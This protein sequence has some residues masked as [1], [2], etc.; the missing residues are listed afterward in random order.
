MS[1]VLCWV[2]CARPA[3]SARSNVHSACNVQYTLVRVRPAGRTQKSQHRT[4]LSTGSP[5][6]TYCAGAR[7]TTGNPSKKDTNVILFDYLVASKAMVGLPVSR[8]CAAHGEIIHSNFS[9]WARALFRTARARSDEASGKLARACSQWGNSSQNSS[10][11]ER[12]LYLCSIIM[13]FS[14][15]L[16]S[17][18]MTETSRI[19]AHFQ[20]QSGW[21]TIFKF[22]PCSVNI[23][24]TWIYFQIALMYTLTI[25]SVLQFDWVWRI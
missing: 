23:T 13:H 4:L 10:Q 14:D 8:E 15:V 12:A 6:S 11:S 22:C 16:V 20:E 2:P 17:W 21:A 25:Y 9:Q 19:S 1:N 24:F 18:F 5:T 7:S 3:R